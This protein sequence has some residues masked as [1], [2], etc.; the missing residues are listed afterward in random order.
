[1]KPWIFSIAVLT[2]FQA[3]AFEVTSTDIQWIWLQR[4]QYLPSTFMAQ[5]T[6]GHSQLCGNSL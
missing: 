6:A 1:M 4:R 3:H 5:P 2:A